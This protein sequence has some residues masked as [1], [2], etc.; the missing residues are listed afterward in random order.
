MIE[1]GLDSDGT[2][3]DGRCDG[4][5]PDRGEPEHL[6]DAE[7]AGEHLVGNG[8]LHQRERSDVDE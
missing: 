7:D 3:E 5:D 1:C 2:D 6:D 4:S 8:A